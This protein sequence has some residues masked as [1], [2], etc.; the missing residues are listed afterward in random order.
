MEP[1][2]RNVFILGAGFSEP[3]GAPLIWDF[4]EQSRKFLNLGNRHLSPIEQA[5]FKE[6]FKFKAEMAKSREK[7]KIDLDNIE[8]LFGLVEMAIRLGLTKSEVR[9]S[10]VF[11]IVKTIALGIASRQKRSQIQFGVHPTLCRSEALDRVVFPD[12]Q[13]RTPPL[14]IGDVYDFFA[15]FLSGKLDDPA[16]TA[17]RKNTV[18]TFNYDLVVD[19]ALSRVG[20]APDY[21]LPIGLYEAPAGRSVSLLKLH[22]SANWGI[23]PSCDRRLFLPDKI[24]EVGDLPKCPGC[25]AHMQPL[26][27]PPSWDKS[28]FRTIMLPVWKKAIEEIQNAT[29][30]CVVGYSMPES[31]AFFQYLITLGL[32]A[33]HQLEKLI[34]VDKGDKVRGKWGA[35]LDP[36]FKERRFSYHSEA[37]VAALTQGAIFSQLSRGE[38]IDGSLSCY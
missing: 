6:V 29:R 16:L 30:I 25:G 7:V 38:A 8:S 21:H 18:I 1:T 32:S 11:L 35:I 36:V 23:C 34:V 27:V 33:N 13:G 15:L 12:C 22:G 9:D 37:F 26:L 2:D 28:E 19:N 5:H 17:T 14:R 20:S 31:D 24:S 4:L 10:T 3:A